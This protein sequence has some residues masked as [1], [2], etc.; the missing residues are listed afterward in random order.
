MITSF[1]L[2]VV[3]Y[4]FGV[5]ETLLFSTTMHFHS[6]LSTSGLHGAVFV[7]LVHRKNYCASTPLDV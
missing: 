1:F 7:G 2:L 4:F 3:S 6:V 5:V